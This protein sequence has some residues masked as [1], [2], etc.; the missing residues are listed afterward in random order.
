MFSERYSRRP[1]CRLIALVIAGLF[2][3]PAAAHAISGS[4]IKA[5]WD[6]RER[7]MG[8]H[9]GAYVVDL[10]TG[11]T[12]Y[13]RNA[14]LALAPASNE[15]LLT[16]S[17]ALVRLGPLTTLATTVR[18]APDA[19]LQPDGTLQ[20][21][22]ILVGAGDPS[23]NDVAMRDLVAQLRA[24]GIRRVTGAI[25]GD[26]S[27]FD[28]RRGSYDSHFGYDS[29]LGGELGALTWGHGRFDS[30]GPAFYAASRLRYFL[31]LS[32]VR[33]S[34]K[35][36]VAPTATITTPTLATHASPTI[37]DLISIT[38]HPSDNFY[39]ETLLKL[40]GARAGTGGSTAAGITAAQEFLKQLG[41]RAKMVDGSG[42]SRVDR[43]SPH[44]IV[45]LLAAMA[46]RPEGALFRASLAA[47]GEW[48]T[49][50]HRMTGTAARGACRAK[51]GTLIGVS[52]LSGYCLDTA[53]HTIAFSLLENGVCAVC[54]KK[55]EDQM[56]PMLARYGD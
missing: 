16:T 36:A 54:V 52:A 44:Q 17:S 34:S 11:R 56:V 51:T 8:S 7:R 39:A 55:L 21:D 47:P 18:A 15:K 30:R 48:G 29:D 53:G 14:D 31:K 33:V 4:T 22:L 13:S 28:S 49:L 45:R 19:V 43:V 42:L 41:V 25:V 50:A 3:L 1:M 27:L 38:N 12:I 20:G 26:E 10:G 35:V 9:A 46:G 40:L 6:K 2:A 5:S 24:A 32:K 23:L 37:A